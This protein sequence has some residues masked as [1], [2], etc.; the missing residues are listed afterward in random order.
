MP[1]K[2]PRAVWF[3]GWASLFTDTA[4]EM[5]YPLLPFYLSVVLGAGAMSLGIIEGVAEAIN[6]FLKLASGHWSDRRG[7]RRPIVIAG[8]ALSSLARP[9]IAV[10]GSWGQVLAIRALDRTGKGI[11]GAPRD[12]MLADFA[13]ATDRGRVFG[14]HRAMDHTGAILGPVLATV[15]LY[16]AP[17][18][19]RLIF[20]LTIVPGAI[21]VGMLFLV[22]EERTD[23]QARGADVH[24]LSVDAEGVAAPPSALPSPL[25][26]F[27][28]VVIVF[29]LGNS[30]D[31]FLLL[32]LSEASAVRRS[33]R[34]SG[35]RSTW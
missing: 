31:A 3:L 27:L 9:L 24:G 7:R 6:S 19:Y 15:I 34:C 32:R 2:I 30:A 28:L 21:A 20:A 26:T 10:T 18:Q 22:N 1:S 25:K 29:S 35:Q 33:C 14:F 17:E 11:R 16:F 5:I 4:G 13:G 23:L 12:A 8:Y